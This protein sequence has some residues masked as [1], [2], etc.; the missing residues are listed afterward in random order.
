MSTAAAMEQVISQ[1]SPRLQIV[2]RSQPMVEPGILEA[3]D[4]I[5]TSH[6]LIMF[7][8]AG[9]LATLASLSFIGVI[10]MW[11]SLRSYGIMHF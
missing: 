8:V 5:T 3:V 10:V 1:P 4:D 6:P 9:A 7:V 2:A 11:L